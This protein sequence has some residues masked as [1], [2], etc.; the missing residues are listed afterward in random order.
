MGQ[1]A[2]GGDAMITV[3]IH[4]CKNFKLYSVPLGTVAFDQLVLAPQEDDADLFEE[5]ESD[6]DDEPI[7]F[8]K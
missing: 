1:K 6:S 8:Q 2:H 7:C 3:T 5:S 4:W